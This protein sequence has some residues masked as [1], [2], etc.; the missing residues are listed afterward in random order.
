MKALT[1]F[2]QLQQLSTDQLLHIHEVWKDEFGL[3]CD[4]VMKN[5]EA[6][7]NRVFGDPAAWRVFRNVSNGRFSE[8]DHWLHCQH[9]TVETALLPSQWVNFDELAQYAKAH[10]AEVRQLGFAGTCGSQASTR[11]K[12]EALG[13][14]FKTL[15]ILVDLRNR[16]C[17]ATGRAD[18][19]IHNNVPAEFN[20]LMGTPRAWGLAQIAAVGHYCVSDPYAAFWDGRVLASSSSVQE[21]IPIPSIAASMIEHPDFAVSLGIDTEY[22]E[23][24]VEKQVAALSQE[25][26]ALLIE[27]VNSDPALAQEDKLTTLAT[28]EARHDAAWWLENH[29]R[30]AQS[31]GIRTDRFVKTFTAPQPLAAFCSHRPSR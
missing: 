10:E 26:K 19:C 8:G 16:Y 25:D 7:I 12:L 21:W 28:T 23:D 17:E 20:R 11:D 4:V 5:T 24:F 2:E 3:T 6:N 22:L 14:D 27:V 18:A 1:V 15:P 31:F 13:H 9:E 30:I 29:D